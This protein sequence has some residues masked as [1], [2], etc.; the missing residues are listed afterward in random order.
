MSA[1]VVRSA[2]MSRQQLAASVLAVLVLAAGV[3][4]VVAAD[5][6][7][8]ALDASVQVADD[9]TDSEP[10]PADH[11]IGT[12][13]D[14]GDSPPIAPSSDGDDPYWL[15]DLPAFLAEFEDVPADERAALVAEVEAMRADGASVADVHHMLHYKL[16]GFGYDTAAAHRLAVEYRLEHEYGLTDEEAA[17]VVDGFVELRESGA[18][19]RERRA[20]AIETLAAYG[21]DVPDG[22][23][24]LAERFDLAADQEAELRATIVEQ[25][26]SDATPREALR[27][28]AEQLREFGVSNAELG[29]LV[30]DLRDARDRPADR[31]PFPLRG[32]PGHAF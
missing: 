28:V 25:L 2:A 29:E 10:T 14:D 16:Y 17:T 32:L 12:T 15:A 31:R 18:E 7:A 11:G 26:R 21:A 22:A 19:P 6:T 5:P 30:R 27:A 3:V 1:I 4:G 13:A 9:S 20:Y 24:R 23:D 8:G